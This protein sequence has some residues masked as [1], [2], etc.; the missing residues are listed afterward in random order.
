M[1]T[2]LLILMAFAV[3]AFNSLGEGSFYDQGTIE[4][5]ISEFDSTSNLSWSERFNASES[6]DFTLEKINFTKASRNIESEKSQPTKWYLN[7]ERDYS[8]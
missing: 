8:F 1:K 6:L 4:K 3:F 5:K 2:R 7:R